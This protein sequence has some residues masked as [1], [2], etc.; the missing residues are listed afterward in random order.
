MY[1][2]WSINNYTIKYNPVAPKYS[3][4]VV[5]GTMDDTNCT[6]NE[7]FNLKKNT[8]ELE[9]FKF[10]GWSTTV[11]SE[12]HDLTKDD[13]VYKDQETLKNLTTENNGIINLYPVWDEAPVIKTKFRKFLK[14]KTI[15]NNALLKYV[16]SIDREDGDITTNV[17]IT[18]IQYSNYTDENPTKL[19]TSKVDDNICVFVSSTDSA[20]N[21]TESKFYVY[22]Y[23]EKE[24][25]TFPIEN[26]QIRFIMKK[27]KNKNYYLKDSSNWMT[28]AI[29]KK[30][31][32]N[33][34]E[35]DGKSY[36]YNKNTERWEKSE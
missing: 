36:N 14:D 12:E 7:D 9:G 25:L 18:K 33:S 23:K 2:Q 27:Y 15:D 19:N 10:I 17:K 31:I 28:D 20:G 3:K 4:N 8:F 6:Y 1:A 21:I 16:T 32:N 29:L 5:T 24:P 35:S 30:K 34:F 26:K 22:V 11:P 13:I